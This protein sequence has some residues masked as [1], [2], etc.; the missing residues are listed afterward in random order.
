ML[1]PNY[2]M[3]A[4]KAYTM[5]VTQHPI[6][7]LGQGIYFACFSGHYLLVVQSDNIDSLILRSKLIVAI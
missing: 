3:F 5:T 1:R 4:D 2:L 7:H 6:L